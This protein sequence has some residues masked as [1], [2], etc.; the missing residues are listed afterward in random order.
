MTYVDAANRASV[1]TRI[2]VHRNFIITLDEGIKPMDSIIAIC[3]ITF[4][5]SDSGLNLS[6]KGN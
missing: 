3:Y 4:G 1:S 2:T 6:G 5:K